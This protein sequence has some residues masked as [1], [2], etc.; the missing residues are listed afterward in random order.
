MNLKANSIQFSPDILNYFC[1][2]FLS[3]VFHL[4]PKAGLSFQMTKI[5]NLTDFFQQNEIAFSHF[6]F[7]EG[8]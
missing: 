2:F 1:K 7:V 8:N 6:Y 3:K 4:Q 5:M